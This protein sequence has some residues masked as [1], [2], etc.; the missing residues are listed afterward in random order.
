[1]LQKF[2]PLFEGSLG[3][4]KG[5]KVNIELKGGAHPYHAK[6]YPVPKALEVK[7]K[8]EIDRLIS[9]G[10]LKKVN[11]SQWGAANFLI[12]KNDDTI[13]F[14]TDFRELNK[15]IKRKPY[16]I[17]KIQDF[18]MKLEGFQWATSL[19]LNMGYYHI[20]L[21]PDTKKMHNCDILGKI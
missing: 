9:A 1:M 2:K 3:H 14:I 4:W 10:V 12:P 5:K 7:I 15:R 8:L 19:D 17:P 18:L 13:R 21:N 11:H 20:E 6:P 16:P